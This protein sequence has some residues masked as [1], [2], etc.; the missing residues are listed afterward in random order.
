[1]RLERHFSKYPRPLPTDMIYEMVRS[2]GNVMFNFDSESTPEG[3]RMT[4]LDQILLN[5]N[6]ITMVC[7][8]K[9]VDKIFG[10]CLPKVIIVKPL[11]V[12]TSCLCH[13]LRQ[14]L[15]SM[16]KKSPQTLYTHKH[17][18]SYLFFFLFH[19]DLCIMWIFCTAW[20]ATL[21]LLCFFMFPSLN[22]FSA[23]SWWRVSF[24][25]WLAIVSLELQI[26]SFVGGV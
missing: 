1:M 7:K 24:V 6:N 17:W 8:S 4:K 9:N 15:P 3:R 23:H 12:G 5:G 20:T 11:F 26:L 2:S 14:S 22:F 25:K 13:L 21:N 19:G 10:Q 16:W 18:C